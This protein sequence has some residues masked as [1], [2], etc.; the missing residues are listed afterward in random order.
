MHEGKHAMLTEKDISLQIVTGSMD[1][2]DDDVISIDA[3]L[4][5]VRAMMI[6]DELSYRFNAGR[7]KNIAD[8]DWHTYMDS[9]FEYNAG[10]DF[11][12]KIQ[13]N[14]LKISILSFWIDNYEIIVG[15]I[16]RKPVWTAEWD[17]YRDMYAKYDQYNV[18]Q[19]TGN[20]TYKE[21]PKGSV[22]AELQTEKAKAIFTKAQD[23]GYVVPDLTMF[24]WIK[25]VNSYGYFVYLLSKELNLKYPN[26]RINWQLFD[27]A[28]ING[29]EMKRNAQDFVSKMINGGPY[30][31]DCGTIDSWFE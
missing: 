17:D 7:I 1:S 9:I 24:R 10:M 23:A 4:C 2:Y 19:I 12:K 16:R 8:V 22:P 3:P 20:Q 27:K 30:P 5:D 31:G 18:A 14:A 15:D 13:N 26:K 11:I 6:R 21:R 29:A 28:F 25:Q